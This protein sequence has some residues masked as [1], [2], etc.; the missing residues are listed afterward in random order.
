VPLADITAINAAVNE[1]KTMD[2]A[3]AEWTEGHADLI[4]RWSNI[5]SY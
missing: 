2:E 1:G 3:I 4:E 5:K